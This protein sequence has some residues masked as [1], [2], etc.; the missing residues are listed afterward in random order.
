[1]REYLKRV[2][3]NTKIYENT[4]K[5]IET[6][7]EDVFCYWY[8]TNR[9]KKRKNF[10][11]WGIWLGL[12]SKKKFYTFM[13]QWNLYPDV[14]SSPTRYNKD[15][16]PYMELPKERELIFKKDG[17]KVKWD[18]LTVLIAKAKNKQERRGLYESGEIIAQ[19]LIDAFTLLPTWWIMEARA[20][21]LPNITQR[22]SLIIAYALLGDSPEKRRLVNDSNPQ[23]PIIVR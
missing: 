7:N 20:L 3:I 4:Q 6:I 14:F 12:E 21:L 18:K 19:E 17:P 13:D 11:P 8:P 2:W 16:T 10:I 5:I 22:Y 15:K 23:W 1:M 9:M